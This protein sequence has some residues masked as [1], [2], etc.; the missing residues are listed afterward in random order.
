M[1]NVKLAL[2]VLAVFGLAACNTAKSV[3]DSV[4]GAAATAVAPV[5]QPVAAANISNPISPPP[6]IPA[7]PAHGAGGA[8]S[9]LA[10][11]AASCPGGTVVQVPNADGGAPF[12][13]CRQPDGAMFLI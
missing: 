8:S 1:T 3:T 9:T 11:P 7:P 12:N 2:A 13:F 6:P 5:T 4:S 10:A